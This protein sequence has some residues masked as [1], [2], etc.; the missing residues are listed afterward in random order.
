MAVEM[1]IAYPSNPMGDGGQQ[2]I[3]EDKAKPAIPGKEDRN[4]LS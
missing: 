3:P 4:R 1:V 2:E